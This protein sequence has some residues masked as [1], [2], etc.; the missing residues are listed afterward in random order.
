MAIGRV[1]NAV[2]RDADI[3][4]PACNGVA[5]LQRRDSGPVYGGATGSMNEGVRAGQL[6]CA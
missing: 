6:S 2:R 5:V 3:G 4:G 1:G